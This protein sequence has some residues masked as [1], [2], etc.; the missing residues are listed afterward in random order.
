M[1]LHEKCRK[2]EKHTLSKFS[3]LTAASI[4]GS[5]RRDWSQ[6]G[7][8]RITYFSA[9]S[10]EK[11]RLWRISY[12]PRATRYFRSEEIWSTATKLFVRPGCVIMRRTMRR[13][14]SLGV[15]GKMLSTNHTGQR[16]CR[17]INLLGTRRGK[18]VVGQEQAESL[19]KRLDSD[20][21][22]A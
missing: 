15:P 22:A 14:N 3:G 19:S 11:L 7:R 9:T 13:N 18:E 21:S 20:E 10:Q 4:L 5:K 17:C 8:L 16:V 6:K 1:L 2:E 12:S